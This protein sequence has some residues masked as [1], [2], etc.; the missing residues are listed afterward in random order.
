MAHLLTTCLLPLLHFCTPEHTYMIY[1]NGKRCGVCLCHQTA[2]YFITDVGF[3]GNIIDLEKQLSST[4]VH[5]VYVPFTWC[6]TGS[7]WVVSGI[8]FNITWLW[9]HYELVYV[10]QIS[11]LE[12]GLSSQFLCLPSI[13]SSKVFVWN[14]LFII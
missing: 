7:V 2:F 14:P 8:Q 1:T 5:V 11:R 12:C 6:Y 3:Y 13:F 10:L 9:K 4:I